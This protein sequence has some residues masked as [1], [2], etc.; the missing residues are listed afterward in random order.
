MSKWHCVH[1]YVFE[2]SWYVITK[3]RYKDFETDDTAS[4]I[5]DISQPDYTFLHKPPTKSEKSLYSCVLNF[6]YYCSKQRNI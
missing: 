6:Q 5:S 4:L 1:M 2:Y 3:N